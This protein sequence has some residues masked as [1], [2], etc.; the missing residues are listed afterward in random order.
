MPEAGPGLVPA[1]PHRRFPA[2][3]LV[4]LLGGR[5]VTVCLP[6]RNEA[7]TVGPIVRVVR[8]QLVEAVPLVAEVL[9]VDDGSL[10][11]TATVAAAAGARV[12]GSGGTGKGQAMWTGLAEAV[13]DLVVFCDADVSSFGAHFVCGL[14]GPLLTDDR[15]E[16]VKGVFD[17]PL[18]GR[19]G[20]GGRVTELMAKP[21]LRVLHPALAGIAQPLAGETA[22]RREA[23]ESVP[24]VAGYGVDIGLVLDV[25]DR[26]GTGAIAQVDLGHR[27]HRNRSLSDLG[28][29]AEVV[30]RTVLARSGLG[31][32]V[33]Q[34]P[35]LATR[36]PAGAPVRA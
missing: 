36:G 5:R 33:P 23:L 28:L 4:D 25:A 18:H 9:V 17:R 32:V 21:L 16:L 22:G 20:Q 8:R 12:V 29:Q 7:T 35:P 24:F 31:A 1:I 14:L 3:A 26:F 30:L 6:A 19:A 2:A 34:C 15:V 11:A 10:D 13:G 27:S